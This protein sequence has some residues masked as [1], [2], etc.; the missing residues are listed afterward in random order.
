[1][2]LETT[3]VNV[4]WA[5]EPGADG[6]GLYRE[7]LLRSMA[8]FPIL[9]GLIVGEEGAK[10]FTALPNAVTKQQYK[11]LGQI[12]A[13]SIIHINRG[14]ECLHELLVN[15]L[16]KE[17]NPPDFSQFTNYDG[18]FKFH[19]DKIKEGNLDSLLEVNIPPDYHNPNNNINSFGEYFFIIS[20]FAAIEQYRKGIR[21][22][23]RSILDHP[24]CFKKYFIKGTPLCSLQQLRK[25]LSYKRSEEGS[26]E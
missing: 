14:P 2:N 10:F 15:C 21:S 9:S 22:I 20:K 8:N 11:M 4:I 3:K 25:E 7:F 19:I 1:M 6:G 18:E 23:S 12:T 17:K 24:C 5:G 13:L 16:F 26:N